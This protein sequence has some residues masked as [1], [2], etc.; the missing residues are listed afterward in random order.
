MQKDFSRRNFLKT[1]ALAGSMG[2]FVAPKVHA[3]ENNTLKVGL[4]G[5]GGRGRGA[6]RNALQADPNIKLVAVG[7]AFKDKAQGALEGLKAA[8]GDQVD[9]KPENVFDGLESYKQVIPQCDV[10]LLCESPHFR[11]ISLRAAIEAGKHV[12]CEKPVAVD[13]P[14]IK[15]VLESA[16]LAKKKGLNIVSG[17]CWR[18]DL[19]VKDMMNRILDGV[20]G[21][22]CSVRETYLTGRLWTRPRLDKDTLMQEQVRNWY[23][24]AW[25]SGDFNTEQHVHSLDKALW[26]FGDNAP[27]SAFGLGARMARTDQPDYGDIYDSMAVVYEYPNGRSVNSFCRQQNGCWNNTDD[28]IIGTKGF[29]NILGS[30]KICD[31]NGKVIYE[32]KKVKSDMY[33]LEHQALFGA[34][35]SGGSTYINN[36]DYMAKS[37]MLGIMGRL[38]C[39]SGKRMTWDEAMATPALAPS[40]YTWDAK[41]PVIPD[42]K[43]RYKIAVPGMGE[44][45]HTVSR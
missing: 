19:N 32:Q 38:V 25:L 7:D 6:A 33:L 41:P 40:G 8:F 10:V 17:L 29:A 3:G 26:A 2:Y 20:I 37:T 30:P 28:Y 24:F 14:G 15:S 11:P 9:V 12:F 16:Q 18:Y 45:Y 27:L 43:G 31:L 36:G 21:E 4:V 39:Y 42:E 5:C 35:R 13:A 34:I 23:N 22:I 44:V 1:T